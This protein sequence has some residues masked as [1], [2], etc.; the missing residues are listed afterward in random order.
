M[1]DSID[2]A[3]A[4]LEFIPPGFNPFVLK[5]AQWTLPIVFRFRLRKWLTTGI[6]R[7]ETENTEQLVALYQK[8]QAGKI[9]FLMAFRH[10]EVDDPLTMLH[11]VSRAVPSSARKLSINLRY[12]IHSHFMYE[13]G[14]TIWAGNWLA[15][16]FSHLGG[17]PIRR[18]KK[19]DKTGLKTARSLF[20]NGQFPIAVAPEGAT[21]GHSGIVSTLEP[22]VAQL[23]F[24]C[25]EDMLKANRSEEVYIL[26]IAIEYSYLNPPWKKLDRLLSKLEI[27]SGLG[28][29]EV[30]AN[31][32]L[33]DIYYKRLLR[34]AEYLLNE[35]EEFYRR[36]YHKNIPPITVETNPENNQIITTRLQRLLDTA[37]QVSEEYFN[38]PSQ[39]TFIERCRRLE[40]AGW[41][42]IYR[43]D[44]PDLDSLPKFKRGLADWIA[45]EADLR[46]RHMR[47]AETF[48]AVTEKYI[49]EKPTPERFCEMT[50]LIF[51][52][53]SRIKDRKLPGRPRLGWRKAKITIGEPLNVSERWSTY[54]TDRQS[55]RLAVTNLTKDIHRELQ[56]MVS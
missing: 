39:G 20:A 42:Y 28:L 29:P 15:T 25:V 26:P 18:G 9:R 35:M 31:G 55:A 14:M 37:L 1:P 48:V 52:M 56:K 38:L 36:Y 6:N 46:M 47:L 2:R 50:L 43:E 19:V 27:D 53:M 45:S 12:P 44:L 23:G 30:E 40:E 4:P 17:F 34:L 16:Y 51:D 3:E 49:Q 24:W 22:G 41:S 32:N 54:Q 21:N 13:R 11:L 10:P 8:F 33:E 5:F 7:F